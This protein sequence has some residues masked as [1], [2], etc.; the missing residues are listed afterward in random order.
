ME[1]NLFSATTETVMAFH[2]RL[3]KCQEFQ[4]IF[5]MKYEFVHHYYIFN[6]LIEPFNGL[7]DAFATDNS[8]L[9]HDDMEKLYPKN[10]W[11][12]RL[13]LNELSTFHRDWNYYGTPGGKYIGWSHMDVYNEAVDK[14]ILHR[15]DGKPDATKKL[16]SMGFSAQE[17]LN[18]PNEPA[19]IEELYEKSKKNY[20]ENVTKSLDL[21][22][23]LYK[24][25]NHI[26]TSRKEDISIQINK[27]QSDIDELEMKYVGYTGPQ[28]AAAQ[29]IKQM[30][31]NYHLKSNELNKKLTFF[32]QEL[33]KCD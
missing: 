17:F 31:L 10:I 21:I 16:E 27:V 18:L 4:G 3:K 29:K 23:M 8:K 12:I 22:E 14:Y 11:D 7:Y 6:L 33:K 9:D 26:I 13:F 20:I 2:N 32:R 30:D 25:V 19:K 1:E 24:R 28:T 5:D 15:I